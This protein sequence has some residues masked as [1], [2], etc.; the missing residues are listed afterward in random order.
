MTNRRY[1]RAANFQAE[2]S[3]ISG[4]YFP[5]GFSRHPTRDPAP[6]YASPIPI[7]IG[8]I[9]IV[10]IP[11]VSIPI[12]PIPIGPIPIVP[13]PIGPIPIGPI[14]YWAYFLYVWG[15]SLTY[16]KL[17]PCFGHQGLLQI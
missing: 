2:L 4:C 11:I 15:T 10:P 5:E 3:I 16:W 1:A 14:P 17:V 6:R 7:P 12:G 13:I 9:P 8:P